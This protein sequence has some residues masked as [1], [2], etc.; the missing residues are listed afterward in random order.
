M[1]AGAEGE[2]I[3]SRRNPLIKRIRSLQSKA[4]RESEQC[5]LLEGTHQVQELL[6]QGDRKSVV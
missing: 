6:A 4:G 5:V 2:P 1:I 3:S